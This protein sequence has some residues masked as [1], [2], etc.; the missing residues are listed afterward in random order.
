MRPHDVFDEHSPMRYGVVL[1]RTSRRSRF[2]YYPELYIVRWEDGT[3]KEYLPH[4]VAPAAGL[5][6]EAQP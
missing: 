2:G 1:E 3:E 5:T 6:R 4:G